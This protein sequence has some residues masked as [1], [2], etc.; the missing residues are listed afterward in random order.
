MFSNCKSLETI[1]LS[2]INLSNIISI[3]HMFDGCSKLKEIDIGSKN[4]GNQSIINDYSFMFNN[5][6]SLERIDLSYLKGS[7]I[8]NSMK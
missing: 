5:C 4:S 7:I 8:H 6:T 3:S 2:N 1:I